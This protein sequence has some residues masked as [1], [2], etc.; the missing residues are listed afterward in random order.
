MTL[1]LATTQTVGGSAGSASA[2]SYSIFGDEVGATGDAFKLLAQGQLPTGAAA[3]YTAPASTS[4]IVKAILLANVTALSV[5]VAMFVNGVAASNRIVTMT[6]P[7][8]GSA[9]FDSEGWSVYD[10]AGIRQYVGAIGPTGPTG[11]QGNTVTGPTGPTGPTGVQGNTV[12]GPTGPTGATGSTVTGPTGPTG[13]LS[14]PV[15]NSSLADMAPSTIKGRQAGTTGP[16]QDLTSA[17]AT[18]VLDLAT[19]SLKGLLAP[20]DYVR[21]RRVWD[22]YADFG[23]VEDLR[24]AEEIT[25]AGTQQ[26]IANGGTTVTIPN[27]GATT[28]FTSTAVD[29]GKRIT[30]TG[31]GAGGA[32]YVGTIVSVTN[33]TTCV[34][35]PAASTTVTATTTFPVTVQWGTDNTTALA[36]LVT[37]INA[38]S[39]PCP[40]VEFGKYASSDW[41]NSVGCPAA[42]VFT[43]AVWFEGVGGS[44]T[45]DVGDYVKTGGTRLAWWGTSSDGGTAFGGFITVSPTGT[46][47]LKRPKF[48]NIYLDCRNGD[49]NQALFGLKLA[50]CHGAMINGGFFVMDA[51]AFGMS[52]DIA[53]SPTEA[54]DMTRF[55]FGEM[56]FRQLDN[57][58]GG[59]FASTTTSTAVLLTN[60]TPQTL[61]LAATTGFAAG[62]GYAICQTTSGRRFLI[63][64][65]A[66][67]GST[68]TN[69]IV[70][71]EDVIHA[72]TTYANAM[73][74]PCNPGLGGA[75]RLSGGSGANT[76]CGVIKQVQVSFGTTFGFPAI[77]CGNSDSIIFEQI[78]MNG[79]SNVTEANGNRQRR[80]GI[81]FA[82]STVAN[83]LASRNNV[84][85]DVDPGGAPG[86][87]QGGISSLGV[88]NAGAVLT[89]PA[90]PNY[91]ELQQMGNGAPIPTVETGSWLDWNGNGMWKTGPISLA[92]TAAQVLTAAVGN[93]VTGSVVMVPPQGWQVGTRLQW[94]IPAHKT[95]VGTSI[96]VGIRQHSSLTVG[97]GTLIATCTYTG[98][99]AIDGGAWVLELVCTSLGAAGTAL[100]QFVLTH[101]LTITGLC[102]GVTA[103]TA[104]ATAVTGTI[105]TRPTMV[106]FNTAAAASGP[107]FLFVEINPITAS[108]VLT[109]DPPVGAFCLKPGNP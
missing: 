109:I 102:T 34:V 23:I 39:Y 77:D 25:S 22:S 20:A 72:P 95:A 98:T 83:T 96:S 58:P 78:M 36:A 33:S 21:D 41:T 9:S 88:T 61:T 27:A 108:T 51:L 4:T 42:M 7:A 2:V 81:Q 53:T 60:A 31:A 107:T 24:R 15:A 62:G 87:P 5:T 65:A 43:K 71:P 18:V 49:Q 99:A 55:M 80:P 52:L 48:S 101:D 35:T 19:A 3:L 76:C 94:V 74:A 89:A 32:Q 37:A 44:H 85:R 13:P 14:A 57:T 30:I 6:I 12:T 45:T 79:G 82:G 26:V 29:G 100:G 17:Q 103:P 75:M 46:Q 40:K 47:S 84:I 16:P 63:K 1:T 10:S 66:V 104:D 106:A 64:Y 90:G 54:K 50:S 105:R 70:A 68:I 67:S 28:P 8:N 38:S 11:A 93:I 97:G 92:S 86:G 59:T 73:V 91:V 69:C 56:C